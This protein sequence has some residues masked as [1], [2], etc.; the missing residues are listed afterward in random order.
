MNS[1]I[2]GVSYVLA[3]APD[4]VIHNG[5]TQTTERLLNP[6]SEYLTQLPSALRTFKQA[7]C[8][9][10]NQVYIG[11]ALPESLTER[12]TWYD[13]TQ[14]GAT[15]QG[16]MGEI[17]PQDEFYL[18]M[19]AC[20]A[21]GLVKLEKAF[22]DATSPKFAENTVM[23]GEGG[24]ASKIVPGVEIAEIEDLVANHHAEGLYH[25]NKLIG[26]VKKAHDTD[27]NLS[28]HV[29]LENLVSKATCVLSL[30]HLKR[31]SGIDPNSIQM[32]L[33]CSE[34]AVGDM[35]QRGG[36]N[37]AKAAAEIA[38]FGEASGSDIRAFCA[39]PVHA[40]IHA[41][42][43]VASGTYDNVVVA[44]GGS[45]AKLGMNGK[46]HVKKGVPIL[47]DVVGGFAVLVSKN[48]G[49][50]PEIISSITG[51]HT[52]S[53]GSS[54][55]AVMTALVADPVDKW[56]KK[57]TE[58]CKYASEMHNPDVTKPAGAGDVPAANYKMIAALAVK[59]GELE[60]TEI[61]AFT[62][63]HGMPGWAPTQGHIPSGVPY[64]GFAREA[65]LAGEINSTMVIGKG[66]LFLG[67]MTNLFDGVSILIQKNEGVGDDALGVPSVVETEV[68]A[69]IAQA[70]REFAE[71]L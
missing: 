21:F 8:Y 65:I 40:L 66:S 5:A 15:R 35:N 39:A 19:Q 34:E 32:V 69:M 20:D 31:T 23:Q 70:M 3:H 49:V 2:K 52:V 10:P 43:L 9:A 54:P 26:C 71:S 41:A 13:H 18:L 22:V 50:N 42:A 60:R 46:D 64:I 45:T 17:I 56:G 4:M 1:V 16:K 30:L 6:T 53:S 7:A 36:G 29:L 27:E 28:A 63:K 24:V 59:R 12:E 44:A 67:R 55:Q 62:K 14:E 25:E 47:E 51:R 11:N 57:L 38:G 58:I 33:D 48:D 37:M 68:R 61:D